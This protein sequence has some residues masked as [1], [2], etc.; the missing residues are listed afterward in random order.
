MNIIPI[1]GLKGWPDDIWKIIITASMSVIMGSMMSIMMGIF[2]FS[3]RVSGSGTATGLS[4]MLGVVGTR[5][6][7]DFVDIKTTLKNT[8]NKKGGFG[9]K[10]M[11]GK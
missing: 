3:G 2:C 5:G 11:W 10:K 1:M 8:M 6:E 4:V 7:N 9:L